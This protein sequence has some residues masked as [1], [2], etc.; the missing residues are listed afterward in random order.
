MQRF[1]LGKTKLNFFNLFNLRSEYES[2][3]DGFKLP[4]KESDINSVNWF[5]ENGH[6]SNSLRYGFDDALQVAIKIKEIYQWHLKNSN[7]TLH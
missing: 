5:V 4:S 2:L 6:S 3:V 7:S 1:A